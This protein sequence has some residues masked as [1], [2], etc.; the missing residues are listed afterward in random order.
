MRAPARR[1]GH[2]HGRR[3]DSVRSGS[4]AITRTI[5]TFALARPAL[6]GAATGTVPSSKLLHPSGTLRAGANRRAARSYAIARHQP[7]ATITITRTAGTIAADPGGSER[8]AAA[9]RT[10]HTRGTFERH[11]ARRGPGTD[12]RP[13]DFGEAGARTLLGW[14]PQS[15]QARRSADA[16]FR[17]GEAGKV[18]SQ[19]GATF[20]DHLADIGAASQRFANVYPTE[21]TKARGIGIIAPLLAGVGTTVLLARIL[22]GERLIGAA[23]ARAAPRA[24]APPARR[25]G[26]ELAEGAPAAASA[27][28]KTDLVASPSLAEAESAPATNTAAGAED[29]PDPSHKCQQSLTLLSKPTS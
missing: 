7:T 6:C 21:E 14:Q 13:V 24:I 22:S 8:R 5:N 3:D 16:A 2:L 29:A 26:P 19:G 17:E 18:Q 10:A 9:A 23:A 12:G 20:D 28:A 4:A 11:C 27:A 15:I 1:K 25:L